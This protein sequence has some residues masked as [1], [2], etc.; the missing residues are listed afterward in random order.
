MLSWFPNWVPNHNEM[1]YASY[2]QGFCSG[3]AQQAIVTA[4]A[5]SFP[6][7]QPDKLT[8]YEL[9]SKGRLF[10][11]RL[12]LDASVYY[13]KWEHIQQTI[14][15]IVPPS[16]AYIVVDL[17]GKSASGAGVD[18]AVTARPIDPLTLGLSL[19]W[20]GLHEDYPV[21]SSGET[22]FPAGSRIDSSPE[23]TADATAEYNFP[24]GS[25]GWTGG[26]GFVGRYTAEQTSTATRTSSPVPVVAESNVIATANVNF[27]VS[28]PDHWRWMI[29]CDNVGHYDT[30]CYLP[31][32][33][34][35]TFN[36]DAA[37]SDSCR[38]RGPLCTLW[39]SKPAWHQRLPPR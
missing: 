19:S 17:N 35:L 26:V 20:N 30:W 25:N 13:M 4:V 32:T 14:G 24:L 28:S 7:V 3:F 34:F 6:P 36:E 29:Y 23:Y 9:G 38:P 18:F 16:T 11:G 33:R 37:G 31:V 27:I 21:Y 8:N 15:I 39:R 12:S 5:P 1:F 2:S 22:L 10:N